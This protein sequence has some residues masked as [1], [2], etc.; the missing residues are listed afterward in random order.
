MT[1]MSSTCMSSLPA[2]PTGQSPFP[3]A[4]T[5]SALLVCGCGVKVV[6]VRE[7]SGRPSKRFP[8]AVVV[9]GCLLD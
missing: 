2:C 5:C 9:K 6:V 4:V 1:I 8:H 7:D 3:A